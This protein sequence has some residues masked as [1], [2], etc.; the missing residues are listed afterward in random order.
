MAKRTNHS[1]EFKEKI[2]AEVK[3]G[4]MSV[5]KIAQKHGLNNSIVYVWLGRTQKGNG[6]KQPKGKPKNAY[7]DVLRQAVLA[8]Y[9]K[10]TMRVDEL[11]LKHKIHPSSVYWWVR[12]RAGNTENKPRIS[13]LRKM[14]AV[15]SVDPAIIAKANGDNYLRDVTIYLRHSR[16]EANEALRTGRIKNYDKA[17]LLMLLALTELESHGH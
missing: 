4:K 15:A 9:D 12:Q 1:I 14:G 6:K 10:K 13:T 7:P 17:H 11:A 3:E 16:R 2:I 5:P 8:D